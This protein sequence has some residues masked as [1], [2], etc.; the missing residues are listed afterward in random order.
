VEEAVVQNDGN[1]WWCGVRLGWMNLAVD[2]FYDPLP[3]VEGM[4]PR[5]GQCRAIASFDSHFEG[6]QPKNPGP[7]ALKK[8]IHASRVGPQGSRG[9]A[10]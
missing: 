10:F 5:T 8:E 9:Q 1:C 3:G 2:H 4:L 7:G 6:G